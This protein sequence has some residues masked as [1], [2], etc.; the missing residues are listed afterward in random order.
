MKIVQKSELKGILV[1][2]LV[3]VTLIGLIMAATGEL[4]W[5][6]FTG[7]KALD[8]I[9][10][11]SNRSGSNEIYSMNLDG[12]EQKQLTNGVKVLSAPTISPLGNHIAFIGIYNQSSQVLAIGATGGKLTQ[13][14]N[15]T[16]PKS[17]PAYSPNGKN[18]AFIAGGKIYVADIE[19]NDPHL[20]LPSEE[21]IHSSMSSATER[22]E[23][24]AY[25]EFAWAPNGSSLVAVSKDKDGN[26]TLVYL[27]DLHGDVVPLTGVVKDSKGSD[28]L[29]FNSGQ[30]DKPQLL[31]PVP[32]GQNARISDIAWAVDKP[33]L[34]ISIIVGRTSVL[35]LLDADQGK[36]EPITADKNAEFESISLSPDGSQLV[37]AGKFSGKESSEGILKLDLQSKEMQPLIVGSYKNPVFSPSGDKIAAVWEKDKDKRQVVVIDTATGEVESLASQGQCFDAIWSPASKK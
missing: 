17:W 4:E 3:G 30:A 9:I 26:D 11:V 13:L 20:V 24:P 14:T 23:L 18:M 22:S 19:G 16:G 12:S 27:S 37:L 36:L 25:H 15:A 8:K 31:M 10:F 28:V 29:F 32:S 6:G 33:L 1:L 34:A 35:M 7:P 5:L 2:F 21:E